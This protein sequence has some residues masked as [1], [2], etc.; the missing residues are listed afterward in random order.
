M[1]PRK[2]PYVAKAPHVEE[3]RCR[4][5]AVMRVVE[6]LNLLGA[7][8]TIAMGCLG[9]FRPKAASS[10][11]GLTAT[12]RTAFGE[13]RATFGGMFV[14]LGLVPLLTG[15]PMAY[16]VAGGCWLGA[17]VGRLVSVAFDQG[18]REPKNFGAVVFEAAFGL[19]LVAGSPILFG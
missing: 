9:L 13:F 14:V 12:T 1:S 5:E 18:Y 7:T 11:T 2:A 8:G 17:A 3:R 15:A 6:V 16:L 4:L 19:L 10:F